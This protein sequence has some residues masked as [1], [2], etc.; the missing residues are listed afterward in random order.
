MANFMSRGDGGLGQSM[1]SKVLP[2]ALD[3]E[4]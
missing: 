3:A 2:V 4:A 1:V